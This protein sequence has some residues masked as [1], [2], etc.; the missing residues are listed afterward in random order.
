MA[1]RAKTTDDVP[2]NSVG[3]VFVSLMFVAVAATLVAI[4]LLILSLARY[5][6]QPAPGLISPSLWLG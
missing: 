3:N 4:A 5:G 2:Q 1:P 6:W